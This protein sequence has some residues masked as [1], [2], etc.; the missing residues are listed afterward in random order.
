VTIFEQYEHHDREDAA[1]KVWQKA[2]KQ[3]RNFS[4][5]WISAAECEAYV[6]T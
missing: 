5:P 3:Y 2:T 1:A 6:M 4:S